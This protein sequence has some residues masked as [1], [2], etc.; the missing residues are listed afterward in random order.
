MWDIY[1]YV[2]IIYIFYIT[3]AYVNISKLISNLSS[4]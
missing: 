4:V 2:Y 3:Y 1:A